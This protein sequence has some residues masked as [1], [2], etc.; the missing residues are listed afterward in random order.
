MKNT[1]FI[2]VRVGVADQ[3]SAIRKLK[4]S[5]YPVFEIPLKSKEGMGALFYIAGFATVLS[6]YLKQSSPAKAIGY[7]A[8][9]I[10]PTGVAHL[11]MVKGEL[12]LEYQISK[13]VVNGKVTKVPV[14]DFETLFDIESIGEAT[15][16]RM[17]IEFKVKPKSWAVFKIMEKIV[18]TAEEVSNLD[19]VKFAFVSSR[20]GLRR[21]VMAQMLRDY[22]VACGLSPEVVGK[23]IDEGLIIDREE[24]I[25]DISGRISTKAVFSF[26]TEKLLGRTDGNGIEF[27]IITDSEDRWEKDDA[28]MKER[29]LWVL[30][31]PAEEGGIL[32]T[33]E[34]LVVAIEGEV[35]DWLIEFIKDNYPE[36]AE[37]LLPQIRKDGTIILPATPVDEKYLEKIKAEERIY[38]AQA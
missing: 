37:R 8:E 16:S 4:E 6:G 29:V 25:V 20:K 13:K 22:M 12:F 3:S 15:P 5:G 32:S 36:E 26:I 1:A 14:F 33:A 30:L 28:R 27:N 38:K 34:G 7:D 18:K 19:G 21:E 11:E 35:S 10:S 24:G 23:V 9:K 2:Q 31:N 17:S